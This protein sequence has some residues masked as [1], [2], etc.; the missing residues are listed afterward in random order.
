M[1]SAVPLPTRPNWKVA[2]SEPNC[3]KGSTGMPKVEPSLRKLLQIVVRKLD[4]LKTIVLDMGYLVVLMVVHFVVCAAL[5]KQLLNITTFITNQ[6]FF[7]NRALS[8]NLF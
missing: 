7:I 8:K 4:L 5:E 2:P 6:E 1:F 3:D